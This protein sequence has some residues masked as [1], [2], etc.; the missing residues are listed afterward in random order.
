[1]C[2]HNIQYL[3][4][5][6]RI[7]TSPC[8]P[9][10]PP[11]WAQP[12][13]SPSISTLLY[14]SS[15]KFGLAAWFGEYHQL[16]S[17]KIVLVHVSY[18]CEGRLTIGTRP[19]VRRVPPSV[20]QHLPAAPAAPTSISF[21]RSCFPLLRMCSRFAAHHA[22]N[23]TIVCIY[24]AVSCESVQ[25]THQRTKN[26]SKADTQNSACRDP[27]S[28]LLLSCPPQRSLSGCHIIAAA[29]LFV[30]GIRHICCYLYPP[31]PRVLT[32]C[33]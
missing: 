23:I 22:E 3:V 9:L 32:R 19:K 28:P 33:A 25:R 26:V 31:P 4:D 17:R 1:M 11:E 8:D 30:P 18:V 6:G 29:Q 27:S 20:L 13:R 12:P 5:R 14:S 7:K 15:Q 10:P 21:S 24:Y 16:T 2:E